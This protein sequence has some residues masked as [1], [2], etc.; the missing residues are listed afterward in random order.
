VTGAGVANAGFWD[1]RAALQWTVDYIGLVGGD[2]ATYEPSLLP[3]DN[4]TD[5]LES[6]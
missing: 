2:P 5:T 4:G 3:N 1:Q 6:R